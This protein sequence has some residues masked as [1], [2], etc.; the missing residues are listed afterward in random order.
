MSIC[1]RLADGESLRAICG[2]ARMPGRATAFRWIARHKEFRDRSMLARKFQPQELTDKFSRSLTMLAVI[3]WKKSGRMIGRTWLGS[4]VPDADS[5][6]AASSSS[7]DQRR[8]P[9]GKPPLPHMPS[10]FCRAAR[11][12]AISA[13]SE[14]PVSSSAH[15]LLSRQ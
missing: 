6:I 4:P 3:G 8:R 1:D 10:K 2:D 7:Y 12:A 14:T 11:S 9:V 5:C 15:P 13:G